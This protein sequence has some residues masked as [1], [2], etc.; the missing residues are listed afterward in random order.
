MCSAF[1]NIYVK[2]SSQNIFFIIIRAHLAGK[3][4][5]CSM[6]VIT[7]LLRIQNFGKSHQIRN[8]ERPCGCPGKPGGQRTNGAGVDFTQEF[9][10][11]AEK[12]P[13]KSLS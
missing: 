10:L 13:N 3:Y 7:K 1:V 2:A 8:S 5:I 11:S 12:F 9:P 6:Y 4:L